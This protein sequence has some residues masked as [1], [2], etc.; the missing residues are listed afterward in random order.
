MKIEIKMDTNIEETYAVIY[1]ND[2]TPELLKMVEK[3]KDMT[4]HMGQPFLLNAK[5]GDNQHILEPR[6]IDII[7]TE[8]GVIMCYNYKGEG[9]VVSR[10]LSELIDKLG[11]NFIRISK[12]SIVNI[13]RVDYL[14]SSFNGTMHIMMKSGV[15]DYISKKY[16]KDFKTRL[17]L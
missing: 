1:A 17:G 8:G 12:S 9:F 7:R 11:S 6:L 4:E 13:N 15:D 16:I 2:L 3:L 14:S 10:P 5:K